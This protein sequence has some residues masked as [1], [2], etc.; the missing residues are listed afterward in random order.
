MLNVT[1]APAKL[2]PPNTPMESEPSEIVPLYVT[3]IGVACARVGAPSMRARPVSEA[4]SRRVR[5]V[6]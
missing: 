3:E 1:D 6:L 5:A 4:A 2:P